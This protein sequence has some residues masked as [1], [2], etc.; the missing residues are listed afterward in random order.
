MKG[1]L[2]VLLPLALTFAGAS[3]SLQP[4]VIKGSKFFYTNGTQ[5]F[6]KGVAYQADVSTQK[7]TVAGQSYHDPL[8]DATACKRDVPYLQELGTNTIRVYAIDPTKDH[9]ECMKLLDAAGIY[10]IS[11]LSEPKVSINRDSP[12]WDDKIYKRYTGVIDTLAGYSNVMGFFAGNEVS[13]MYNNTDASAF[14][15]AAVRDTKAYLKSKGYRSIP[16]G[17]ATNDD[18]D[19]R[20]QL[21]DYFNCG[22][23]E[24]RAEFWGYNIYSWCGD[25]SYT[26]SGYDQRTAEFKNYS[27][28]SFFAEYGCNIPK[29]EP[30]KFTE[31]QALYSSPMTDVFSG[32]IVY[33]YFEEENRYGL[34]KI[35]DG[36]VTK[37]E[38][39]TNL[40][41]QISKI[42]PK[43][44]TMSSYTPSNTSPRDCPVEN[45][46]W[47]AS[48]T[49]PPTPNESLCQCMVKSL[50][51]VAKSSV[52]DKAI[53]DLFSFV[54]GQANSDC[55]AITA[56]GTTGTYG[57]FSMCS[58]NER[59]SWAFNMYYDANGKSTQSCDFNG[60]ATTQ[61]AATSTD[62]KSTLESASNTPKSTG[63]SDSGKSVAS[64][65]QPL[66]SVFWA[67][68]L[69][70]MTS[71]FAGAMSILV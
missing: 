8:A 10:V 31:V 34:V 6:M 21:A 67:V 71:V 24:D 56:N 46:F 68:S 30:R 13:N 25:S 15:K 14:V 55:S 40:K 18:K 53:G 39:F 7:S 35:S 33:M 29:G 20:A 4:I 22:N 5:F 26:G 36:K 52:S 28:P 69:V 70:V 63:S 62:C 49:L 38:D 60:N 65:T 16:V 57:A 54:C 27:I 43:G 51:C 45:Q 47:E 3:A 23:A 61:T 37:L 58:A 66:G 9:D 2:S 50:G 59:L 64:N 32:G 42:N 12:A 44:V 41:N 48:S 17:Y 19:I 1:L 11:D